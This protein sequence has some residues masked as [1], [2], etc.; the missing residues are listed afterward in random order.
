MNTPSELLKLYD[1]LRASNDFTF[2]GLQGKE[3]ARDVITVNIPYRTLI[4]A[5]QIVPFDADSTLLIQREATSARIN[6][7]TSYLRDEL[8]ALPATGAIVEDITVSSLENGFCSVC[9]PANAFRYLFDGQGRL[10]AIFKRIKDVDDN[11]PIL[12]NTLTVKLY[13]TLGYEK[14]NQLFSDWNGASKPNK[15]I[16]TAMD[17]RTVINNFT[18]RVLEDM[19][20]SANNEL[21]TLAQ[22]ID[23]TKASVSTANNTTKL[24]SLNQF[25]EMVKKLTGVTPSS[26]ETVFDDENKC[27]QWSGFICKYLSLLMAHEQINETIISDDV[28][29][30]K[31]EYI[32]AKATWLYGMA[33]A[34]RSIANL[35]LTATPEGQ[36]ADWSFM[37]KL[38]SIDFSHSN[39]EWLGR[40][41][42]YRGG[43]QDKPFNNK[44]IAV[45]VLRQLELP[46]SDEL[47]AIED[48][49]LKLKSEERK[50]KREASQLALALESGTQEAA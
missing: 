26:A 8:A 24:W 27:V 25:N 16:C 43:Y 35:L 46:I 45:Y 10:G 3:G 5:F 34:G 40:C 17:T 11:D 20:A 48:E 7:I 38:A 6:K 15:S 30:T 37:D 50:A 47:E 41:L 14:D 33:W 29:K 13:K 22:K 19:K 9:L 49:V 21:V 39:E 36:H 18:K 2:Y 31:S 32:I 44:A 4:K 1:Q 12:D 23:F 42:D 28:A